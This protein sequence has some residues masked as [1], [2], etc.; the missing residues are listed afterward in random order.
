MSNDVKPI[1]EYTMKSIQSQIKINYQSHV[2]MLL[3]GAPG[4]GKTEIIKETAYQLLHLPEKEKDYTIEVVR[5][6]DGQPVKDKDGKFQTKKVYHYQMEADGKTPRKDTDGNKIPRYRPYEATH[7]DGYFSIDNSNIPEE[8]YSIPYL[9]NANPENP[10]QME[11]L[12]EFKALERWLDNPENNGKTAVFFVD[13]LTSATQDDQRTLMNF[14]NAGNFPNGHHFDVNRVFFI[15]AGNPS[16]DMPGYENSDAATNNIEQAVITRCMTYFVTA[17]LQMFLDWGRH[18]DAN[19]RHNIHPYL[20]SALEKNPKDFMRSDRDEDIRMMTP[21]TLK[22]LSDYL[23]TCEDIMH[24]H[25]EYDPKVASEYGWKRATVE[26]AIG[27]PAANSICTILSSLDSMVSIKDLFGDEK[28]PHLVPQ[29]VKKFEKLSGF[30]QT[31][32]ALLAVDDI[33][34][35]DYTKKNNYLKLFELFDLKYETAETVKT[36]LDTIYRA[37]EGTIA[38]TIMDVSNNPTKYKIP[39]KYNLGN[40]VIEQA[41]EDIALREAF[42]GNL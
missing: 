25:G 9:N 10:F 27:E 2:P 11:M 33:M 8:S 6:K 36:I 18:F 20:I 19:G 30:E 5:D 31:Y 29:E 22:K 26:A 24:A 12:P 17:D 32:I 13:E 4:V 14:I 41:K 39:Q 42:N 15:L 37:P 38:A 21:R 40:K 7:K 1:T 16:A 3:L 23:Y 34:N 35:I 28:S